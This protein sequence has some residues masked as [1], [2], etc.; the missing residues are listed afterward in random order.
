MKKQAW[1]TMTVIAATLIAGA[2]H[3]AAGDYLVRGRVISV[4]PASSSAPV[5]GV[6]VANQAT[7]EVDV[8]R[9]L[10]NNVAVELIAATTKHDVLSAGSKIGTVGV[11]PPTLTVQY[12]FMP[13]AA[14]RPYAGAGLNYTRFYSVN[15][16][17]G[18]DV[19]KNS[20]GGALQAGV[21]FQ[22][23]KDVFINLDVKKIFMK[24]DVT[25][26]GN[27][28]TTLTINPVV[29]GLGVGMKF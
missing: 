7:L 10:T 22:V 6:S 21:D 8:T 15:L 20:F 28:L 5:T 24:T 9:F 14:I 29:I 12:H 13:E 19:S 18:L 25:S 4:Q 2:A 11:L 3:A 17:A 23:N 26:N 1:M 16:P 27:Y